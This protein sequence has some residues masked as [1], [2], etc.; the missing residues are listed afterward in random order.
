MLGETFGDHFFVARLEDVQGQGSAGEQ[1]D[2]EREQ[3]DKG[4]QTVSG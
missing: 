1:D 2:I 3:G 4:V